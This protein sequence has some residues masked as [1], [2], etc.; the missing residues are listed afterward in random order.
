MGRKKKDQPPPSQR[1]DAQPGEPRRKG[2]PIPLWQL[3]LLGISVLLML[4]GGGAWVYTKFVAEKPAAR[5]TATPNSNPSSPSNPSGLSGLTSGLD[6]GFG[7]TGTNGGPGTATPGTTGAATTPEDEPTSL[8]TFSPAVFRL[9]FS[10]FAGFAMAYAVRQFVKITLLIAG[11]ILLGMFG[12]QY[13]GVVQIDWHAIEG[14]YDSI[15][16]FLGEQTKSF[17][18]FVSGYLP[19]ATSAAAG[20]F[21]GFR[22]K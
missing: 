9:G 10:F 21:I 3:G 6:S 15:A 11:V 17:T 2:R 16:A 4:A 19:S 22:K 13:A 8:E 7:P 18:A 14:K 20:A 12:L 1:P 5:A